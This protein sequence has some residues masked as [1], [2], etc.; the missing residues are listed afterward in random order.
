[1]EE[2]KD[3][4]EETLNKDD[5]SSLIDNAEGDIELFVDDNFEH[6]GEAV[7]RKLISVAL[8]IRD[9][10]KTKNIDTEEMMGPWSKVIDAVRE[11]TSVRQQR[12][13]KIFQEIVAIAQR[14]GPVNTQK[15]LT[16]LYRQQQLD[17]VFMDLLCDGIN[18][19]KHEGNTDVIEMFTFFLKV[20]EKNK[21]VEKALAMRSNE[22]ANINSSSR[23]PAP[24]KEERVEFVKEAMKEAQLVSQNYDSSSLSYATTNIEEGS[25]SSQENVDE[26]QLL[27]ASNYLKTVIADAKGNAAVLQK[28]IISDLWDNQLAFTLVQFKRVV[29]D[30]LEASEQAGYVNRVKLLK[31]IELK[32]LVAVDEAIRKRTE[33]VASP[34]PAMDLDG[35]FLE[36][37]GST[38]YHAPKFIDDLV[39][40]NGTLKLQEGSS[41]KDMMRVIA[42]EGFISGFAKETTSKKLSKTGQLLKNTQKQEQRETE[43]TFKIIAAELCKH[44]EEHG[45]AVAD[46]FVGSDLVRRVRIEAGLFEEHYDQSE[47]WVGKQA[48]VGTLL[49]VP[50][51]RGDKVI[52]MCGGHNHRMAVEGMSRVV[53]TKGEIEPCK[54]EAKARAPM[55]KFNAMKEVVGMCDQLMDEMKKKVSRLS[56]VYERSDVMLA[57]YP[58]GGSR[59]ARHIDNTTGDGRRLTMLIYLN[60]GWQREQGGALRL[61]PS[62]STNYAEGN[63]DADAVDVYPEC[64][65]LAMFY[66]ADIPHEVLPTYGDRHAITIWYYDSEERERAVKE[67]KETGAAA[68]VSKAGT[69]AQ[70]EAKQFIADLMGGDDIDADGGDPTPEELSALC[71]K[72][73]DLSD[74]A[75]GVVASITGAPSV[76]S[77]RAGF[78]MLTPEDL[79]QMRQLFRRMGLDEHAV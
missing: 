72:V 76:D 62:T 77:F 41:L 4:L 68:A 46:K 53:K 37:D 5:F 1:M 43:Q 9:D 79:K 65:R 32:C 7:L 26:T 16:A 28:R 51:V 42:P 2:L 48:D 61:T 47:I 35:N 59:F 29:R 69:D 75:L 18:R 39:T 10:N 20:I 34:A 25:T 56:G 73:T 14:E 21:D 58:G 67:S 78:P 27:A 49:S 22:D 63:K 66:S 12:A 23:P 3:F 17:N 30:N 44:L 31:F 74:G 64:G 55:R 60:P 54:I 33:E 13:G 52:W 50:S 6:F 40:H 11:V 19:A 8:K 38:S 57:N 70:R 36:G 71:N 15:T 45:W 24:P